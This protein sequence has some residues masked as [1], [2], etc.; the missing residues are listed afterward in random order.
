MTWKI[1]LVFLIVHWELASASLRP[2]SHYQP[3]YALLAVLHKGLSLPLS[4]LSRY[5]HINWVKGMEKR[6]G[7]KKTWQPG[8]VEARESGCRRA[9]AWVWVKARQGAQQKVSKH[10]PAVQGDTKTELRGR[11]RPDSQQEP[12]REREPRKRQSSGDTNSRDEERS[13]LLPVPHL[14]I[15]CLVHLFLFLPASCSWLPL[16]VFQGWAQQSSTAKS[17]LHPHCECTSRVL[18]GTSQ[19]PVFTVAENWKSLHDLLHLLTANSL[20]VF[21]SLF[22]HQRLAYSGV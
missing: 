21:S 16:L 19:E 2:I 5:K 3:L 1:K 13:T 12:K 22:N 14:A 7:K 18:P 17:A 11:E 4:Y 8:R 20:D 9:Q 6:K 10:H 15:Q